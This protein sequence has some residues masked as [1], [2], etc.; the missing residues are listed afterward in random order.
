VSSSW[1]DFWRK[2]SL[3]FHRCESEQPI[4]SLQINNDNTRSQEALGARAQGEAE[5]EGG[6]GNRLCGIALS[7]S[8][9]EKVMRLEENS[10]EL[11]L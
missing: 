3:T 4:L 2:S 7:S 11:F 10:W 6:G 8:K 5:S 1:E 9:I